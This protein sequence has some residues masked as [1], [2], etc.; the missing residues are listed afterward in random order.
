M[1][2]AATVF[3]NR[4]ATRTI[5]LTQD[6][7]ATA[8]GQE[9]MLQTLTTTFERFGDIS[10]IAGVKA[11][12]MLH[13]LVTMEAALHSY[14]DMFLVVACISAAGIFPALWIG[15]R[16]AAAPLERHEDE[17]QPAVTSEAS[18]VPRSP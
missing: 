10:Q 4:L 2:L 16:R 11:L 1:A 6:Q 18:P 15:K 3:Q 13:R 14:H 5:V 8:F 12:A 9:A 7:S 17:V